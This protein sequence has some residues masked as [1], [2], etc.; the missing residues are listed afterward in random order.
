MTV[1]Y[2]GHVLCTLVSYCVILFFWPRGDTEIV[3]TLE[4]L[5]IRKTLSKGQRQTPRIKLDRLSLERPVEGG[6]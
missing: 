3:E 2:I 6:Q 1:K 5:E 4:T